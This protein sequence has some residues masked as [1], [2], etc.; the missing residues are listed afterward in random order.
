M[1]IVNLALATICF[2]GECH[3]VL[4]GKNT[5]IGQFEI[6]ERITSQPGYGGDVMQFYENDTEWYAIHR[7]YLLNK[8][9]HRD[10]RI[11]STNVNDRIITNGCINVQPEI[12]EKLKT[13]CENM[14]LVIE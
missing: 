6:H 7:L 8:S 2:L 11:Q 12:Y 3:P 5:P 4:I 14:P 9:Q 13:C 10:K 1:I